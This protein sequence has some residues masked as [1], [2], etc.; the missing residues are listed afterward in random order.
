[1]VRPQIV[2]LG[3]GNELRRDDGIGPV[4]ARALVKSGKISAL[5]CATAPE[6]FLGT[7]KKLKPEKVI[8][9]DACDFGGTPGEFRLFSLAELERMPWATVST[10]TLPLSLMGTLI[11]NEVG[12]GVELLGVQPES[13]EFGEGVSERVARAKPKILDFLAEL[14]E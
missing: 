5:D 12:C 11:K 8:M 3:I 6:N 9:V 10:H 1:V 4:I 13:V 14:G 7:I 2:V